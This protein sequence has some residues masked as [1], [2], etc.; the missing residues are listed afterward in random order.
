[1][2]VK[3]LKS[4]IFVFLSSFMGIMTNPEILTASD[5]IAINDIDSNKVVETVVLPEKIEIE[6]PITE[7]VSNEKLDVATVKTVVVQ[8]AVSQVTPANNTKFP[9]G[10]QEMFR[11]SSTGVDA[12]NKVARYGKLIWGHN[13]TS[14]GKITSLRIG[15]TFT[16]TENGIAITYKVK[17][18]PI[19]GSAG[20]VLD[21]K[22]NTTLSYAGDS[23]YD[24]IDMNAVINGMGHSLVLMTCYGQNSRYVVV[25]DAI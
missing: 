14:F 15:D 5:S 3:I 22:S 12:G 13:Y 7:A 10:E 21:K 2:K 23:R 6:A 24:T 4:V 25:A 19:S 18:N 1:M 9:W 11:A 17:A 8:K 20:V 16:L